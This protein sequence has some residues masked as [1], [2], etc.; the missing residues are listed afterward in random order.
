M[1]DEHELRVELSRL[2]NHSPEDVLGLEKVRGWLQQQIQEIS[3]LSEKCPH[4]ITLN[5]F[6]NPEISETNCYMQALDLLPQDISEWRYLEIQPDAPFICHLL[7]KILIERD[8]DEAV[9]GDV[10]VYFDD[11]GKP[12]HA[13]KSIAGRVIS[14]WGDGCTH[15]WTHGLWEVPNDYGNLVRFFQPLRRDQVV[16]AY[17]EWA[18]SQW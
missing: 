14:K 5:T 12:R 9:D 8:I 13:G 6:W 17:I 10:I 11:T 2:T 15:I 7:E 18:K 3:E 1:V 4:S 16:A